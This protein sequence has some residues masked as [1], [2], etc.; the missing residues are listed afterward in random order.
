MRISVGAMPCVNLGYLV[1]KDPLPSRRRNTHVDLHGDHCDDALR[2][3][4]DGE[5]D[6]ENELHGQIEHAAL[7]D[8]VHCSSACPCREMHAMHGLPV[9]RGEVPD[10]HGDEGRHDHVRAQWKNEGGKT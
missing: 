4:P 7:D 8:D 9:A 3:V 5:E 10:A 6:D 1:Y 2:G